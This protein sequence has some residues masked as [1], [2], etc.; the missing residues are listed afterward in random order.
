MPLMILCFRTADY[1]LSARD[2]QE[3]TSE[4][5]WN[6]ISSS[7]ILR[8]NSFDCRKMK[9]SSP[10]LPK[11]QENFA[12]QLLEYM[13]DIFTALDNTQTGFIT[14]E[15][16][17]KYWQ[18]NETSYDMFLMSHYGIS[19]A[20]VV[21]C[22]SKITPENGLFSFRKFIRGM[23]MAVS[24]AKNDRL[25]KLFSGNSKDR[26]HS[27]T[28]WKPVNSIK[29]CQ[30]LKPDRRLSNS[31]DGESKMSFYTGPKRPLQEKQLY[32]GQ[33]VDGESISESQIKSGLLSKS[34]AEGDVG[35]RK[36]AFRAY[37]R[38]FELDSFISK[39]DTIDYTGKAVPKTDSSDSKRNL[40]RVAVNAAK[41][42]Y[43]SRVKEVSRR[44]GD[45]RY[46]AFRK[47]DLD[48]LVDQA[49]EKIR[50]MQ[51][52]MEATENARNWY[53]K[54]IAGLQQDRMELR[55]LVFLGKSKEETE[56]KVDRMRNSWEALTYDDVKRSMNMVS[57]YNEQLQNMRRRKANET[58][59][60]SGSKENP[61]K[62]QGAI[63]SPMKPTTKLILEK[64]VEGQSRQI[65]Q[66]ENEKAALVKEVF[67]MKGR[68]DVVEKP[69]DQVVPF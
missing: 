48:C 53:T 16:L 18:R 58:K 39:N 52:C 31:T 36:S 2:R 47:T 38:S 49:S 35:P 42:D 61:A 29:P 20:D 15:D 12:P 51:K 41:G 1:S 64:L 3:N 33:S 21:H 8:V 28:L 43:A 24:N 19:S 17:E 55:R 67:L 66:L 54:M 30:D 44:F 25:R 50:M 11:G 13:N 37:D 69:I 59:G 4:M 27:R 22:M 63:I 10:L 26:E 46:R 6:V 5:S 40:Q 45:S 9:S 32:S 7:N 23:K 68:L 60:R 57:Y 62:S 34:T 56:A 65:K 14:V